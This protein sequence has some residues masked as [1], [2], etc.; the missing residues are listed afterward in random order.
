M[1]LN[2]PK[3]ANYCLRGHTIF[4]DHV[5]HSITVIFILLHVKH[6]QLSAEPYT[7]IPIHS[8]EHHTKSNLHGAVLTNTDCVWTGNAKT[9]QFK[10]HFR[11]LG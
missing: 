1:N 8:K 10:L 2:C 3:N 9:A 11:W 4:S 7:S 5:S 6:K